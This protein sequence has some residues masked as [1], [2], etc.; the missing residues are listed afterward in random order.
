[1]PEGIEP[2]A[3]WSPYRY[4]TAPL[5]YLLTYLKQSI[6]GASAN[7]LVLCLMHVPVYPAGLY[8]VGSIRPAI[9]RQRIVVISRYCK[10]CVRGK[11]R[12]AKRECLHETGTDCDSWQRTK[13]QLPSLLHSTDRSSL[14]Q[15][16][17][18][19]PR[20]LTGLHDVAGINTCCTATLWV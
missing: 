12:A 7:H 13:Q 16:A 2:T 4:A 14:S 18:A 6:V 8:A 20:N 10:V 1:V 3:Y 15:T 9:W 17:D 11:L 19:T 5:T